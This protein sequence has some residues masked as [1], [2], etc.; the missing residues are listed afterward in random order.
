MFI[1]SDSFIFRVKLSDNFLEIGH[2]LDLT[3]DVRFVGFEQFF[4]RSV[5]FENEGH[6]FVLLFQGNNLFDHFLVDDCDSY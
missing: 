2:F 4:L 6:L 3:S 1:V 5:I